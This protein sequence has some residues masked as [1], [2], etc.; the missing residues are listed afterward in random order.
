MVVI[1]LNMFSSFNQRTICLGGASVTREREMRR[2]SLL[3]GPRPTQAEFLSLAAKVSASA[4]ALLCPHGYAL[5]S[6]WRYPALLAWPRDP[7]IW[8][9]IASA[10]AARLAPTLR[11]V[12]NG[13]Q[14]GGLTSNSPPCVVHQSHSSAL[15]A[16]SRNRQVPANAGFLGSLPLGSPPLL[17]FRELL[18]CSR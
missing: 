13:L 16:S 11:T 18:I 14:H 9:A 17:S 5:V 3:P 7:T 15:F 6:P 12:W 4:P 2:P 10:S 8:P 1:I